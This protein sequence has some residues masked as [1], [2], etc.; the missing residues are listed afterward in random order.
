[1]L[2][3]CSSKHYVRGWLRGLCIHTLLDFSTPVILILVGGNLSYCFSLFS[4]VDKESWASH[5]SPMTMKGQKGLIYVIQYHV[6]PVTICICCNLMK[7]F[8]LP[9]FQKYALFKVR[10]LNFIKYGFITYTVARPL[11]ISILL[12]IMLKINWNN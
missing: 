6:G 9:D 5:E 7:Y 11:V 8:Y 4:S 3:F 10:H 12:E 1:M 2:L